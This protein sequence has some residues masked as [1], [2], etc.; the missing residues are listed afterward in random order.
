MKSATRHVLLL[1]GM[2]CLWAGA[3]SLGRSHP[4][5]QATPDGR[6]LP[7]IDA[8]AQA[9]GVVPATDV[10]G[11]DLPGTDVP[12]TDVPGTGITASAIGVDLITRLEVTVPRAGTG[13]HTRGR[14]TQAPSPPRPRAGSG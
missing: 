9:R 11:T 13:G 6:H 14:A 12:E 2:L 10:P 4:P 5:E 3:Y 1:A 7:V 8:N